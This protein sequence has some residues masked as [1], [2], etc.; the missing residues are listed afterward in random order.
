MSRPNPRQSNIKDTQQGVLNKS[1]DPDFD[2]LAI[3]NLDYDP[4]G[5]LKRRITDDLTLRVYNDGTY[6]YI[7][8]ALMVVSLKQALAKAAEPKKEE[9]KN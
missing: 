3:E 1:L 9:K 6:D 4:T 2:V 5:S 7:C 8:E